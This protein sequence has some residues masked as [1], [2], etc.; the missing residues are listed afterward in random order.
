MRGGVF[1]HVHRSACNQ[2]KRAIPIIERELNWECMC[3]L[4]L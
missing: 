4:C 1:M 2:G 3:V